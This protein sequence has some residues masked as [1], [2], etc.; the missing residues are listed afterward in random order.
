VESREIAGGKKSLNIEIEETPK[1]V[2]GKYF[3]MFTEDFD[4]L[5][6]PGVE[7]AKAGYEVIVTYV[8]RPNP[9]NADYPYQN[10]LR[11]DPLQEDSEFSFKKELTLEGLD[12]RLGLV[13]DKLFGD[14]A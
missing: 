2:K 11:I 9:K 6:T 12:L 7:L 8:E 4:G 1:D 13:E 5:P 3:S 14:E 10:V